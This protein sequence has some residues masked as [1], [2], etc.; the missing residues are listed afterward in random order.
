MW[1]WIQMVTDTFM[2]PH[3][4][5][6]AHLEVHNWDTLTYLEEVNL[7]TFSVVSSMLILISKPFLKLKLSKN[8][9]LLHL[10]CSEGQKV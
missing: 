1:Q 7:E 4:G 8:I 10:P 3:S 6:L 2:E 5:T 9:F